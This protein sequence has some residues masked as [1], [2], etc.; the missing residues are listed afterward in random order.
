MFKPFELTIQNFGSF[1]N[2][3]TQIRLDFTDPTLIVGLNHDSAIDGQMDSNGSG[4]TT[5]LNAIHYALYGNI[6]SDKA[7]NADDLINNINKKSMYVGL[8]FT[9]G[10]EVFYK[11][12]RFRKNKLQGGTG[13]RIYERTG[14]KWDDLFGIDDDITPDSIANSDK[15]IVS[16][17][18]MVEE[19]FARI[20]AF[21]ATHKPFL[22]L[23]ASEQTEIIE[24]ICG[25]TELSEKAEKQKK[26][27]KA[28]KQNLDRLIEINHTIKAQR[29]QIITQIQSAKDKELQWNS[30]H[31]AAIKRSSLEL[32]SL[33]TANIDYDAQIELLN[34]VADT[35]VKIQGY[36]ADKRE[37]LR[38]KNTLETE[39]SRY[40][41]WNLKQIAAIKTATSALEEYVEIDAGGII[42]DLRKLVEVKS[43]INGLQ[44]SL[45]TAET[46]KTTH[47]KVV[48][49]KQKEL[50]HLRDATCPYCS[51][52]FK[53]AKK[54]IVEVETLRDI[55]S[56]K[57]LLIQI[58]I[59]GFEL[60][61]NE[62]QHNLKLLDGKHSFKSEA[63]VAAYQAKGETLSNRLSELTSAVCPYSVDKAASLIEIDAIDED[64]AKLERMISSRN[65]KRIKAESELKFSSLQALM[66]SRNKIT[67]IKAEIKRLGT[68]T[69]PLSTT[70]SEL[71]A[72][73]LEDSKDK[74]IAEL[75]N[76]IEHQ[77][78]LVKLLLKK[79]SFIR[80]TL[81]QKSLPT[82]NTRLR[83]YLDR[84]GF[85][86]KVV[87]QEDLSVKISQ[88][89]NE[90]GFGNL[91]SGQKA[92]INL[93]LSFAFRDI[94]QARH[95]KLKFCILDE[96][97]DVGLGN[98][99]VQ[100]A[101]KMIKSVATDE[102]LSMFVISH[103]DEISN[104]FDSKLIV[105]L[106]NGFSHV[107]QE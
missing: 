105:E 38:E 82:L 60:Q 79:D 99:G 94:L 80:K 13:V 46:S 57:L 77:Q 89:G 6:V 100:L 78:F 16:I 24:E 28:D 55:A 19:V 11:V 90:I 14:G 40:D 58:D 63:D 39:I 70:V 64:V 66:D 36:E 98:V 18:G 21:S 3:G 7:I 95:G 81:L 87:F 75:E 45:R 86:H 9:T 85:L 23:P 5:I 37:L 49:D 35:S 76:L 52:Q 103:R 8:V 26:E 74:E 91:S 17:M 62:Y 51:Q 27:S 96:C 30:N 42:D 102:K 72:I 15:K 44:S 43:A 54:K 56:K 48:T 50:E 32:E 83:Y 107:T 29:D 47:D 88:F 4:K 97:L 2:N 68:E 92:R 84:I 12:E 69:N 61:L 34:F 22:F 73:T 106:K 71:S 25:L 93:S 59:D 10:N 1:G 31:I 101:A 20:V 33:L 104:M 53:D 41:A 65:A 67:S